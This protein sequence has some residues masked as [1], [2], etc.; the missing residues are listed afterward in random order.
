MRLKWLLVIPLISSSL[1]IL[2]SAWGTKKYTQ[3]DNYQEPHEW[4]DHAL[5][6]FLNWPIRLKRPLSG[7]KLRIVV[8]SDSHNMHDRLSVPDGD[9]LIHC[10]DPTNFG[11][12]QELINFNEFLGNLPHQH[13][14]V[15][16]GNHEEQVSKFTKSEIK[17][18]IITNAIYLEDDEITIEGVK[19]YGTPWV[20]NMYSLLMEKRRIANYQPN[21]VGN[22]TSYDNM[23]YFKDD[24]TL[25]EKWSM[26]P[27]DVD[28]LITHSA[29]LGVGD[30]NHVVKHGVGCPLLRERISQLQNVAVHA[31]GHLH[32]NYGISSHNKT[33]FINAAVSHLHHPLFFD[34]LT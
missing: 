2:F 26:I 28:F 14:L 30:Y 12:E 13:K 19:F 3:L 18:S 17:K 10:G 27:D 9:V 16:F 32:E 23:F 5:P 6:L 29:P 15:I 20:P 7:K 21:G 34:L 4:S 24:D 22:I 33:L 8:M 11:T 1:Y 25:R 31:F